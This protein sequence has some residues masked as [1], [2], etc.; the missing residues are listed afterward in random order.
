MDELDFE[1][2]L[3]NQNVMTLNINDSIYCLYMLV[4][5]DHWLYIFLQKHC[6]LSHCP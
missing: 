1:K 3:T 4:P 2:I 6:Y 5:V